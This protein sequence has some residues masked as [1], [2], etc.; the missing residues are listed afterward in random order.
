MVVVESCRHMVVEEICIL[1]LV[2]GNSME[3]VVDIHTH[4][5]VVVICSEL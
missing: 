1:F 2:K 5:G 4:V 3:E